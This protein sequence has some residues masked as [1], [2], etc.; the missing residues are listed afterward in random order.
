[1]DRHSQKERNKGKIFAFDRCEN[2]RG[3]TSEHGGY[4]VFQLCENY[5]GRV[6]GGIE[7]TW[8]YVAKGLSYDEAIEVMNKK[9]GKVAFDNSAAD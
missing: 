2:K 9:L 7:K 8:R 6:K 1:M 4:Y 5:N 3:L